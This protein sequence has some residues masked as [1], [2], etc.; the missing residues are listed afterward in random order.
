MTREE[1]IEEL[2]Y[3]WD[4]MLEGTGLKGRERKKRLKGTKTLEK[5]IKLI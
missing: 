1:A 3:E 2:K 4:Y 5:Y